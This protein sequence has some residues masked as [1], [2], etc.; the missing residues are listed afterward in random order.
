MMRMSSQDFKESTHSASMKSI[1]VSETHMRLYKSIGNYRKVGPPNEA[2][3]IYKS[4][5]SK[6][7]ELSTKEITV[8]KYIANNKLISCAANMPRVAPI[9]RRNRQSVTSSN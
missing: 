7:A 1:P 4:T 5:P 2:Q 8:P 6:F 9:M 3:S